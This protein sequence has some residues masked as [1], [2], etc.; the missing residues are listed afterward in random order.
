[1]HQRGAIMREW[2]TQ[3]IKEKECLFSCPRVVTKEHERERGGMQVYLRGRYGRE[4][5]EKSL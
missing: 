4:E 5:K 2:K 1:M 3:R